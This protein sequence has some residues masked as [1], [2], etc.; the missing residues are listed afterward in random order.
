MFDNRL[1][2]EKSEP[3]PQADRP[4]RTCAARGRAVRGRDPWL[5][6]GWLVCDV[7]G[8]VMSPA[9]DVSG[10]QR[11]YSCGP[12]CAQVDLPANEVEA[13]MLLGALVRGVTTLHRD[14]ARVTPATD[15][16]S[17]RAGKRPPVDADALER[18]QRCELTERTAVLAAAYVSIR[19]T[20]EG[21]VRPV[22]QHNASAH[23]A[24]ALS[25]GA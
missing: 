10:N 4:P 15:D 12:E 16:A 13:D 17:S 18:W 21:K 1:P 20:V 3:P 25:A 8:R 14:L 19:V 11:V 5:L 6:R 24:R 2:A 22:W 7:C 9:R 23:I